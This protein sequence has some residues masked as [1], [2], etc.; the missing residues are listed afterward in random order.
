L[1]RL[2]D[3]DAS[4]VDD[5]RGLRVGLNVAELGVGGE[6]VAGDVDGA[7]VGAVAPAAGRDVRRCGGVA[8]GQSAEALLDEQ[9]GQ[10]GCGVNCAT[11]GCVAEPPA[12]WSGRSC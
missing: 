3:Y 9:I 7:E 8:S 6:V 4:V 2:A 12:A 1:R 11:P 5:E 10:F